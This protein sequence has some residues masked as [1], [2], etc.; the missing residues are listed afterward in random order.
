M[1]RRHGVEYLSQILDEKTLLKDD[2]TKGSGQIDQVKLVLGI[3]EDM[4]E[5][6]VTMPISQIMKASCELCQLFDKG[7]ALVRCLGCARYVEILG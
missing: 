7:P 3:T 1:L 5:V 2:R 6:E 4:G